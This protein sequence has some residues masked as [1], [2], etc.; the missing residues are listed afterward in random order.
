MSKL[1][2]MKDKLEKKQQAQRSASAYLID[3]APLDKEN[4]IIQDEVST[5]V[6]LQTSNEGTNPNKEEAT[7]ENTTSKPQNT[8]PSEE[9]SDQEPENVS[10]VSSQSLFSIL[11]EKTKKKTM[12]ETHTRLTF[13]VKNE[14]AD[15]LDELAETMPRGFLTTFAN[16]VI[17]NGLK[18][19]R[20]MREQNPDLVK[21]IESEAKKR[22]KRRKR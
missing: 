4:E 9:V 19:I 8:S 20:S 22:K 18:E 21:T 3:D 1:N 2:A 6:D 13:L 10:T 15:E 16:T 7:P 14:L 17:E 11:E 12:E 5:K